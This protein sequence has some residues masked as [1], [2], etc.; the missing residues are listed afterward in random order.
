VGK[1]LYNKT[2]LAALPAYNKREYPHLYLTIVVARWALILSPVPMVISDN[3]G[4][5]VPAEAGTVTLLISETATGNTW[6]EFYE[7]QQYN[8]Y[9]ELVAPFWSNTDLYTESGNLYL[10]ASYPIDAET[11]EEIRDY[12]PVSP[13]QINPALLVQ[14]FFTGQA[15][16]RSRK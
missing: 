10:A 6:G 2:E 12:A 9:L 16:R 7:R 1:Y 3:G 14:S 13:V 4:V 5:T 8:G 11:G 15:V